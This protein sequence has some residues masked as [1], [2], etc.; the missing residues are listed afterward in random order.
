MESLHPSCRAELNSAP[1]SFRL[2]RRPCSHPPEC[3]GVANPVWFRWWSEG[4][5]RLVECRPT[6]ASRGEPRTHETEHD[7]GSTLTVDLSAKNLGPEGSR[8][9]RDQDLSDVNT[10]WVAFR[11]TVVHHDWS[12]ALCDAGGRNVH[13]GAERLTSGKS[14]SSGCG[15]DTVQRARSQA[16]EVRLDERVN[17]EWSFVETLRRPCLTVGGS[18]R[19]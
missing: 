11:D 15:T 16:G 19:A 13:G 7:P 17:G 9:T 8:V 12:F 10:E 18:G 3:H 2:P 6:P 5:D 14:V 4:D 1:R